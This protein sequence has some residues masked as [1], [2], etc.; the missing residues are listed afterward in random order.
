MLFRSRASAQEGL[1]SNSPFRGGVPT[2]VATAD[3][4]P[5][6]AAEVIERALQRNLGV[7]SADYGVDRAKGAQRV[8]RA[9]LLPNVHAGLMESRQTRN[10]EAFGFP[11][12]GQF[13]ALVGPFNNFDARLY[14]SQTIFDASSLRDA[15]AADHSVEAAKHSYR[16]ARDA[17]VLVAANLYLQVIASDARAQS[18]SEEHTSELQSH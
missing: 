10:L 13:P 1:P 17:V 18:R 16:G 2:G 11:L 3:V 5:L 8:E 7:L 12:S 6:S 9:D 4:L 14:L 15:Q